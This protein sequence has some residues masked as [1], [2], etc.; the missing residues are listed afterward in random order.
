MPGIIDKIT[1]QLSYVI[2]LHDGSTICRHIDHI[3]VREN[4]VDDNHI[5]DNADCSW[6]YI[7]T[8][9]SKSTAAVTVNTP[10]QPTQQILQRSECIWRPPDHYI[11][12][13]SDIFKLKREKM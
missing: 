12:H 6:H 4:H 9:I 7:D 8:N 10:E 1:G 2:K 13:R 5:D 3:K 11:P